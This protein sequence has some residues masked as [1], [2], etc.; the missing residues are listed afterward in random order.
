MS[1]AKTFR[2]GAIVS[3]IVYMQVPFVLE[4]TS[5]QTLPVILMTRWGAHEAG[6]VWKFSPNALWECHR[7]SDSRV[8][9]FPRA[10]LSL[11]IDFQMKTAHFPVCTQC[12]MFWQVFCSFF[13]PPL[14]A[15]CLWT[16]HWG[17]STELSKPAGFSRNGVTLVQCTT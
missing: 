13:F 5:K 9:K 2:L 4:C 14:S 7:G 8:L 12:I 11:G 3:P 16:Y 15:L 10:G 6:P 17:C 1:R